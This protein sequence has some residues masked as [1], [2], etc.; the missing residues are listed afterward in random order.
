MLFSAG[1]GRGV[2]GAGFDGPA[3]AEGFERFLECM[4]RVHREGSQGCDPE[5][6]EGIVSGGGGALLGFG[7]SFGDGAEPCGQ[8]FAGAG[9]GVNQTGVAGEVVL[10]GLHL[11]GEDGPVA[12]VEPVADGLQGGGG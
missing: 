1:G 9:S 7:E 4:E 3:Q 5:D 11:E 10:P 2:S 8:R 6:S 12:V